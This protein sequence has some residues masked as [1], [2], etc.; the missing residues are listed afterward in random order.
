MV[1]ITALSQVSSIIDGARDLVSL[2]RSG[3]TSSATTSALSASSAEEKRLQTAF[4][5]LMKEMDANKDGK[6]SAAEFGGNKSA[7]NKADINHDGQLDATE[8][9]Q[10]LTQRLSNGATTAAASTAST[11]S[12]QPTLSLTA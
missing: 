2:V 11:S 4:S 8:V 7:F 9:R 1:P 10:M 12:S 3:S 6:L 5:T